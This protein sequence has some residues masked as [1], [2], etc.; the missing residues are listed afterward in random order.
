MPCTHSERSGM[1]P[2]WLPSPLTQLQEQ[3]LQGQAALRPQTT[4]IAHPPFP[5]E[6]CNRF[7]L[8]DGVNRSSAQQ[9]ADISCHKLLPCF[10]F[11]TVHAMGKRGV[12][13]PSPNTHM[14]LCAMHAVLP[15]CRMHMLSSLSSDV[16]L[17]YA[18]SQ[19]HSAAEPPDNSDYSD[20]GYDE[21]D[22]GVHGNVW[23]HP[24]MHACMQQCT[25]CCLPAPMWGLPSPA[26]CSYR[27]TATGMATPCIIPQPAGST[28]LCWK[29]CLDGQM[30]AAPT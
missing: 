2:D 25:R 12:I 1:P 30:L 6:Y 4:S 15:R 18:A 24:A 9:P 10:C 23:A 20:R 28:H 16:P 8:A 3:G 14:K 11:V 27:N 22:H 7:T 5:P 21:Q 13:A 26:S 29:H 19:P 17:R